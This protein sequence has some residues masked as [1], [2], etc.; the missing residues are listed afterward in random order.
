MI[1]VL[2]QLLR[3][4]LAAPT[5]TDIIG[6]G[7]RALTDKLEEIKSVL[8]YGADNTGAGDSSVAFGA[9]IQAQPSAVTTYPPYDNIARAPISIGRIPA[10]TYL[11]NTMVDTGGKDVIWIADAGAKFLGD[12]DNLN[13]KLERPG[14]RV[15]DKT[16]I[17]ALDYACTFS[18]LCFEDLDIT[19][20]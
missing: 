1:Q 13:G 18:S 2:P 3:S 16:H 15:N 14:S 20:R 11:L 10:G 9:Y 4:D 7:D 12:P 17:G 5:G 19:W 6:Y 8:D